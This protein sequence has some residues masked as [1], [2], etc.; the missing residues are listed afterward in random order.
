MGEIQSL[1]RGLKVMDMLAEAKDG[2]SITE[3]AEILNV[4]KSSAS[5][6]MQTL[7]NNDWAEPHNGSRRYCLGAKFSRIY[8]DRTDYDKLQQLAHPF[9]H[10]LVKNTGECAHIAIYLK[11][12]VYILDD[13]EAD[14]ILRVSAGIK[15]TT[16][17]HC[18]AVGKALL[19]FSDVHVPN[20][21][22]R[23]TDLT[24]T[25]KLQFQVHLK[26]IRNQ[27]FAL[28]DEERE[29]GVRCIAAPIFNHFNQCIASIGI[30]GPSVRVNLNTIPA[31]SKMV[32][33]TGFQ[34]SHIIGYDNSV[35]ANGGSRK[36][37]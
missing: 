25:D 12:M 19:A 33:D 36:G 23:F 28:D 9:L 6:I 8:Y 24:I 18:T 21:M 17:L 32:V 22:P 7:V 5:R 34:L 2:V 13:V 11:G 14:T 27:G 3:I 4:D 1:A 16:Y 37:K 31:L 10:Y 30:S 29:E 26:D 15:R 20:D 35:D